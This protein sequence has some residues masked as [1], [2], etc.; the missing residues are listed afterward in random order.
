M[1]RRH[2]RWLEEVQPLLSGVRFETRNTATIGTLD[3]VTFKLPIGVPLQTE[4]AVRPDGPR[5]RNNPGHLRYA[6]APELSIWAGIRPSD[7]FNLLTAA[8]TILMSAEIELEPFTA[9]SR[10]ASFARP[11]YV[12]IQPASLGVPNVLGVSARLAWPVGATGVRI[13]YIEAGAAT[14]L[15]PMVSFV[16]SWAALASPVYSQA[17]VNDAAKGWK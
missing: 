16:V 4:A 14:E 11:L 9:A 15:G 10:V 3:S 7:D 12:P 17:P 1:N 5:P 2:H 13:S 6:P 8:N